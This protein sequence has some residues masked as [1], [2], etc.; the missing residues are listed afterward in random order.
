M[1]LNI[2]CLVFVLYFTEII[3]FWFY[4]RLTQDPIFYVIGV[5]DIVTVPVTH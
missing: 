1:S 3:A 4:S 5:A 2:K